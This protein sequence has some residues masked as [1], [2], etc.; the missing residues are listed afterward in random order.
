MNL[1]E[2]EE[3]EMITAE[4]IKPKKKEE[5]VT[6]ADVPQE[7]TLEDEGLRISK[8]SKKLLHQRY[9]DMSRS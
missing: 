3:E 9:Q 8:D 7:L 5:V 2:E 4:M 1:V 6:K